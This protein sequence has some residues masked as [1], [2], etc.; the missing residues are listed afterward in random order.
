MKEVEK[1]PLDLKDNFTSLSMSL[2]VTIKRESLIQVD[3]K[4]IFEYQTYWAHHYA[5]YRYK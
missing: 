1:L 5:H 4:S 2:S 3:A